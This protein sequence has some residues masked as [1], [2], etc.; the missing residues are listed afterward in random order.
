M[1]KL[2]LLAMAAALSSGALHAE[3]SSGTALG[4]AGGRYVFGQISDARRDQYMLDTQTGRVWLM[5]C[6]QRD[7]TSNC[8]STVLQPVLYVD[9]NGTNYSVTPQG[10]GAQPSR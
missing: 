2:L 5:A 10:G 9:I 1:R 6:S 3:S 8:T 7:S 4:A